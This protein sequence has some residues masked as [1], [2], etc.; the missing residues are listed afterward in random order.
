MA[1]AF[2]FFS[3]YWHFMKFITL[4]STNF[5]LYFRQQK[6]DLE[7]YQGPPE[8]IRG[9]TYRTFLG[10]YDIL[11]SFANTQSAHWNGHILYI[12]PPKIKLAKLPISRDPEISWMRFCT[13]FLPNSRKAEIFRLWKWHMAVTF[14]FFSQYWHFMQFI[15]L[16]VYRLPTLFSATK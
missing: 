13:N 15:T 5:P 14:H 12:V 10:I 7:H 1:I 2:Q 4:S 16:T 6:R 9:P 3:Q 11:N 8:F